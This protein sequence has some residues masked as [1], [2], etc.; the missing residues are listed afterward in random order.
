MDNK[1]KILLD[2]IQ[3]EEEYI[4]LFETATLKKIVVNRNQKEWV[5]FIT[6]KDYLPI[7]V[8]L[9]LEEKKHNLTDQKVT[10]CY[11]VLG[12]KVLKKF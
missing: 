2:K 7:D 5:V 3:I 9:S 11:E 1:L 10:F 6:L 12:N 4:P 8:Y